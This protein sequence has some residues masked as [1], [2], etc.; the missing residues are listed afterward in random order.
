[1]NKI[2]PEDKTRVIKTI[3]LEELSKLQNGFNIGKNVIEYVI[4]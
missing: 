2:S 3:D 4:C 1:M